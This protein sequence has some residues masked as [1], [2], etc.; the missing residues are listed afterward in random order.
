MKEI[1]YLHGFRSSS[2]S[3]KATLLRAHA[4]ARGVA[5]QVTI[6]DLNP[7]PT[8]ALEQIRAW[9]V[10]REVRDVTLVGSS[11][12]AFYATVIGEQQGYRAVLVNPPVSPHTH[13]HRYVGQ[14]TIYWTGG[15]F[16]FTMRDVDALAAMNVERI[17]HP[18]QYWLMAETADTTCDYRLSTQLYRGARVTLFEGGSHDMNHFGELMPAILKHAKVV[19]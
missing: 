16:D 9:L 7:A 13:L 3:K 5:D 1:L 6:L 15:V 14:Q 11:L 4:T 8:M 17:N 19:A 10:G 2:A 12:G 18:A